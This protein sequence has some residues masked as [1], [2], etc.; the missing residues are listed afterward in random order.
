MK[1]TFNITP[2]FTKD[3]RDRI[4]IAAK[5]LDFKLTECLEIVFYSK[6]EPSLFLSDIFIN[7]LR[8]E[9]YELYYVSCRWVQSDTG[10][11]VVESTGLECVT[12]FKNKMT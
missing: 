1:T 3:F 12:D 8:H 7:A 5:L 6:K 2:K 9:D 11:I 10:K 4:K